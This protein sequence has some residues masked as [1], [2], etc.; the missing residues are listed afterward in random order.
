MV[1]NFFKMA[2]LFVEHIKREHP[3]DIAIVAYYGSYASGTQNPNSDFDLFFIPTTER[4]KKLSDCIILDGIGIDF[5]SISWERAERI[6]N[7]DEYIVSVIAD[8]KLLYVRSEKDKERIESLRERIK[9]YQKPEKRKDMLDKAYKEFSNVYRPLYNLRKS[10]D[11][12]DQRI[13]SFRALTTIL[14]TVVLINQTYLKSGW[15]KNF[16]QI[17]SLQLQPDGLK[18]LAHQVIYSKSKSEMLSALEI[19]TN[20]TANLL[21]IE[22]DKLRPHSSF[23][24]VFENFYEELRSTFLKIET[25]CDNNQAEIAFCATLTLQNEVRQ[26]LRTVGDTSIEARFSELEPVRKYDPSNLEL[27]KKATTRYEKELLELL[28]RNGVPI[29]SLDNLEE[30]RKYLEKAN[31]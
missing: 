23:K 4:G 9:S 17:F 27:L 6:A 20:R 28:E 7:F 8:C 24:D 26:C 14:Q 5:F 1:V 31:Y 10:D 3:E 13:E 18:E 19:L 15:G 2:D 25:A 22:R 30:F 16:N 29:T 21:N 11:L 12:S